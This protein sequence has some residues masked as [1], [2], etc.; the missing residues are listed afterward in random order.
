M[1]FKEYPTILAAA[2]LPLFLLEGC[3]GNKLVSP[4]KVV[5]LGV[6]I[7]TK[8]L[9]AKLFNTTEDIG[10]YNVSGPLSAPIT[11]SV[12]TFGTNFGSGSVSFTLND[13]P[14][15]ADEIL[16]VELDDDATGT[17]Q[18][19]GATSLADISAGVTIEMGSLV[20]SCYAV[21]PSFYFSC[22]GIGGVGGEGQGLFGF[23]SDFI[24][25]N[26]QTKTYDMEWTALQDVNSN[27][28]GTYDLKDGWTGSAKSLAYL[29]N[30]ELVNFDT[31]PP[32]SNFYANGAA[33]K[34]AAGAPAT[35][36]ATGDVYCVKLQGGTAVGHAWV[37]FTNAGDAADSPSFVYRV[38]NKDIP[39]YAYDQTTTDVTESNSGFA[40]CVVTEQQLP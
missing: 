1:K 6:V 27:C 14:V 31:V 32:D 7:S 4:V 13:I 30:G 12:G 22:S 34:L 40:N 8:G 21:N 35:T 3:Q 23:N 37:L 20:R 2:L 18:G 9:S 24:A 16:S 11:G 28:L 39:Y 26:A 19:I 15:G 33:A 10:Y 36:L 25:W 29:G 5:N 38:Q 17:P